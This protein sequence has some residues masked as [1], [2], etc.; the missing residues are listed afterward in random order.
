MFD[1]IVPLKRFFYM[2]IA[3]PDITS[4]IPQSAKS[5]LKLDTWCCLKRAAV[6]SRLFVGTSGFCDCDFNLCYSYPFVPIT[7]R[8]VVPCACELS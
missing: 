4:G 8:S 7:A 5:D 3:V 1:S 2:V 6:L